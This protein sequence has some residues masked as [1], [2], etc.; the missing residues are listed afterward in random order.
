[1]EREG[2]VENEWSRAMDAV[3]VLHELRVALMTLPVRQALISQAIFS[4][5]ERWHWHRLIYWWS[6]RLEERTPLSLPSEQWSHWC[7]SKWYSI[8]SRIN[9]ETEAAEIATRPR[10]CMNVT[11]A[12]KNQWIFLDKSTW[13]QTSVTSYW[14]SSSITLH[15]SCWPNFLCDMWCNYH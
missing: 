8:I 10:A 5:G 3:A 15:S 2:G 7:C 13:E 11:H 4:P 12:C 1:M 9:K 6:I 14:T